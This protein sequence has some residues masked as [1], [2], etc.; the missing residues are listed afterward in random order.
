MKTYHFMALVIAL[1][2]FSRTVFGDPCGMVPPPAIFVK[3]VELKEAKI[4]RIGVQKT[5]IFYKDGLETMVLRP[6]FSGN[7]DQFGM[8]IPFPSPPAIRKVADNIFEQ[9]VNAID[10]P[11]V[12]VDLRPQPR[13][14]GG[15]GFGMG[16]FGGGGMGGGLGFSVPKDEVKVIEQKAVGMYEVAVLA[17]GS[18]RALKKWMDNHKYR[19]PS[20]METVCPDY[21]ELGWC[22]VA[23]KTKVNQQDASEPRPG[24]R[25]IEND[26]PADA[27]FDGYVQAMGFRFP[28]REPVIPMRLSVFNEGELR[29]VVYMLTDDPMQIEQLPSNMVKRQIPGTQLYRNLTKPLPLRVLG[30]RA[31]DMPRARLRQLPIERDQTVKNGIAAELFAADMFAARTQRLTNDYEHMEAQLLSIS[32]SL[33]LRGERIDARIRSLFAQERHRI[34]AKALIGLK[35]M[36]LTVI[37]GDFPRDVIGSQNLTLASYQVPNDKNRSEHYDSKT[38]GPAGK[39]NGMLYLGAVEI[40]KGEAR[41]AANLSRASRARWGTSAWLYAVA[42]AFTAGVLLASRRRVSRRVVSTGMV[43]CI[44]SLPLAGIASKGVPELRRLLDQLADGRTA[45][46]AVDEIAAF[47]DAAIPAL[48]HQTRSKEVTRKGW[49]IVALSTIGGSQAADQLKVLYSNHKNHTVVK[50]WA[51]AAMLKV[52]QTPD[53]MMEI[54]AMARSYPSL[55]RPISIEL[56]KKARR[57]DIDQ[58]A[59][60]LLAVAVTLP[61]V[62]QAVARDIL[63]LGAEPL[64]DVMVSAQSPLVRRKAASYVATIGASDTSS[65]AVGMA[66]AKAL[67]FNPMFENPVWLGGPLFLPSIKW[68]QAEARLVVRE[69]IAWRL[70]AELN[71][72]TQ[73]ARQLE[74][75]LRNN[76][77]SSQAKYTVPR[78][79]GLVGWLNAWKEIAGVKSLRSILAAQGAVDR[80]AHLLD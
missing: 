46:D 45:P 6:G 20:G 27:L 50:I 40:N 25:K 49:A 22:F 39:K 54:V 37:D 14:F 51:A 3:G 60:G 1:S 10:P 59:E 71:G 75:N 24:Q 2:L 76:Q 34:M 38:L 52:A 67:R 66:V 65:K 13:G 17:A 26:L 64:I 58:G 69:L 18:A 31:K 80:Y 30:G 57:D 28:T 47:G 19:Y 32:E 33:D 8:L 21:V 41:I 70:W 11:E 55:V 4:R 79:F 44:L 74:N 36:T 23:V 53:E 35:D 73:I 56:K 78:A 7:V 48:I 62:E 68:Q 77:L 43:L 12:V 9:I 72:K 16:G 42:C 15:G 63:S 5:Y 61:E 29:N